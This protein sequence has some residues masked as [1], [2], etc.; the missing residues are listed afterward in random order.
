MKPWFPTFLKR[1]GPL[2]ENSSRPKIKTQRPKQHI[3]RCFIE[4]M[5]CLIVW[6]WLDLDLLLLIK[7]ATMK[8][9]LANNGLKVW[10]LTIDVSL[11]SVMRNKVIPLSFSD[12]TLCLMAA[13]HYNQFNH[14][15][16]NGLQ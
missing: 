1:H 12:L 3:R 2:V 7:H 13:K 9:S 14:F 16:T 8:V 5:I 11:I 10:I 4:T 6:F 15:G